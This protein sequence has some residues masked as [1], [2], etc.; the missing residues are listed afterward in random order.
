MDLNHLKGGIFGE[1]AAKRGGLNNF[2]KYGKIHNRNLTK[3]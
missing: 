3:C 1:K 2:F